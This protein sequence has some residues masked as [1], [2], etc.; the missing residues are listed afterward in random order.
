ME[1]APRRSFAS[2]LEW[3]GWSRPGRDEAGAMAALASSAGRFAIVARG[4]G[5]AFETL[6]RDMLEVVERLPGTAT[7][8][9]G[10]PDVV[11]AMDLRP[12]DRADGERLAALVRG[13]WDYLGRVAASAPSEL[14]RGP[15]GGGRDLG[16]I[17]AHVV[18]AEA[19]YGRRIGVRLPE[20]A[21][22]DVEAVAI[23]RAAIADGL[24]RPTDGGP[25][26]G[27]RW[28]ARYVARRIAWHV[29]DHAWEIQDRAEPA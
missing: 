24:A 20:P 28:P 14:R 27:G 5:L 29:L 1:T 16:A 22:G 9:F 10:A 21:P 7:T 11:F 26:P 17:V 23:V 25:I 8:A 4:A 15:R 12:T 18:A 13:S 2:A 3:P 19:A 6:S